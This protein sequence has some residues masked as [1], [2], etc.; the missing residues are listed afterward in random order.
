MIKKLHEVNRFYF[1]KIYL[2]HCLYKN[3]KPPHMNHGG[4]G[5]C[6]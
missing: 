6:I 5:R 4:M 1:K 2:S 3:N